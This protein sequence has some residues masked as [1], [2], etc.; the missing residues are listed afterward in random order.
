MWI[1]MARYTLLST[2]SAALLLPIAVFVHLEANALDTESCYDSLRDISQYF[3][4]LFGNGSGICLNGSTKYFEN[5]FGTCFNE[6]QAKMTTEFYMEV[7]PHIY[8]VMPTPGKGLGVF[9]TEPIPR[10]TKIIIEEPL[11]S[12]ELP[13]MVPGQGYRISDMVNSLDSAF[14]SLSAEEQ[15]QYLSLHEYRYPSEKDQSSLLTIFRSNAYN[16]GDN[17]VGLFPRIARINHSC[18]PNC[19]NYWSEKRGHRVIFAAVDIKEG[20]ELTVSYIPLLKTAN[21]RQSRL[22]QY[23]FICDCAAC[24][25][26]ESDRVRIKISKLLDSLEMIPEIVTKKGVTKCKT[27]IDLVESEGLMDYI[28]RGYRLAAVYSQHLGHWQEAKNWA[29]K[30]L[31]VHQLAEDDSAEAV[32]AIDFIKNLD[33]NLLDY[34]KKKSKL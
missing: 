19:G 2:I 13:K 33:D 4:G 17:R 12:I 28:A 18:K 31:K 34:Q 23:G 10:G 22:S 21:E 5:Q 16:T 24:H 11:V 9:A 30:E 3:P 6:D 32:D 15:E 1:S 27:L 25:S 29:L 8:K 14:G 26:E 20:E 7:R